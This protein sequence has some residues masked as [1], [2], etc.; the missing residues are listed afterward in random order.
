MPGLPKRCRSAGSLWYSPS[1]D[2]EGARAALGDDDEAAPKVK[3]LSPLARSSSVTR[4]GVSGSA[5]S[6]TPSASATAL[7]RQTGVLIE[8]PSP[9]PFAPNGVTGDGVSRCWITGA[10]IP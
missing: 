1:N 9:T 5:R 4:D 2:G 7:A 8:L 10:G 6:A 3:H